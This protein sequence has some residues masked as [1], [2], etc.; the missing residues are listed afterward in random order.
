M[1][2]NVISL[3]CPRNLVDSE[4]M[5]GRL[6][7]AGHEIVSDETEADCIVVNT[8]SFIEPAVNESVDVILEMGMWK[9]EKAGRR[10]VVA[11]CL[12]Q[13]YGGELAKTLPEVDAF[14]GTGAFHLIVEAAEG[15]IKGRPVLV[16]PPGERPVLD[17]S[18]P[19]LTTTPGHTAYLKIAEGCSDR[20][21]YCIIP[22]LRGPQRSR[23]MDEVLKEADS[24][25]ASGVKELVLVAQ[26]TM[27]YG[28]DLRQDCDLEMLLQKLTR[29]SGL[30]WLRVLY[31]HP[32]R[33]TDSL[34]EMMASHSMICSYFDIPVQHVSEPI[35]RAMGRRHDRGALCAVFDRIRRVAPDA[36]LRT[37]FMVGF[38]GETDAD[39]Q[40]LLDFA[41]KVRFNHLGAFIYSD[42]TDLPSN[43]LRGHVSEETKQKRFDRLMSRQL[44]ISRAVNQGFVGKT[45]RVLVEGPGNEDGSVWV[46]RTACQAPEIDGM[47]YIEQGAPRSGTFIDV[48]MTEAHAYDL[49]G[50]MV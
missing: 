47:V 2:I 36:A 35:L 38:P 12:P 39:F 6:L 33:L 11:G 22:K 31:G 44:E 21:T 16:P 40:C 48:F 7:A 15:A 50:T 29:I 17:L 19:R 23:P 41:E 3:G 25:V 27:A 9:V 13:R 49:V 14:L 18:L 20:C 1:K 43:A 8:C 34:L 46:G 5:L 42:A 45:L 30:V 37:T 10:L 24:L 32:G 4:I 28:E 26:N